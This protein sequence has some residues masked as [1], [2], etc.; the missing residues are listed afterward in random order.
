MS[1]CGINTL[2]LWID[3]Q[4]LQ[5]K[6]KIQK[7]K[8]TTT[9]NHILLFLNQYFEGVAAPKVSL[10]SLP[11]ACLFSSQNTHTH[12]LLSKLISP[13]SSLISISSIT[14]VLLAHNIQHD[15]KDMA[16]KPGLFAFH[17]L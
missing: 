6:P 16:D 10:P 2:L 17:C 3:A 12:S 4:I 5:K 13:S 14:T 1:S 11:L 7:I 9:S 15:F 8:I